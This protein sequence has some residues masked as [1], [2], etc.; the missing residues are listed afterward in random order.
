MR[1]EEEPDASI[2]LEQKGCRI[3]FGDWVQLYVAFGLIGAMMSL[4]VIGEEL[5]TTHKKRFVN[6]NVGDIIDAVYHR[7]HRD[8]HSFV[9]GISFRTV[10]VTLTAFGL[11]G[12][13]LTFLLL[14][15]HVKSLALLIGAVTFAVDIWLAH[16]REVREAQKRRWTPQDAVGRVAPVTITIPGGGIGSGAVALRFVADEDEEPVI[17]QAITHEQG[18]PRGR[19]AYVVRAVADDTV[20]VKAAPPPPNGTGAATTASPPPMSRN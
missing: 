12:L 10:V 11:G 19:Y 5:T 18:L 17:F 6:F 1:E 20:E 14:R 3:M 2:I 9:E 4:L 16:R 7:Q 15:F 13:L 8:V